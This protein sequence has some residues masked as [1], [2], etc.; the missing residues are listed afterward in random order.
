MKEI[1]VEMAERDDLESMIVA[2]RKAN[3]ADKGH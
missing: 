2:K 1:E 3:A